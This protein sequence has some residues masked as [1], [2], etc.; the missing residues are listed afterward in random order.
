MN[1][2]NG[3]TWT[4]LPVDIYHPTLKHLDIE[5]AWLGGE[6]SDALRNCKGIRK[7]NFR[8][9]Y[10]DYMPTLD[11][12][13]SDALYN[14]EGT[15]WWYSTRL[16][17]AIIE[18]TIDYFYT[19][20]P[21]PKEFG[22]E[23]RDLFDVGDEQEIVASLGSSVAL[24]CTSAGEQEEFITYQ[25]YK[26]GLSMFGKTGRTLTISSLKA[27]D[28]ADY[29]VKITND[30]VKEYDQNSNYGEVFTK[31]FHIVAEPVAP[32]V[33]WAKTTY[34]GKEIVLRFTKPMNPGA[35]G[36]QGFVIRTG[37]RTLS[38]T[39]ARTGG[40]LDKDFILTLN[41]PLFMNEV[42]FIDYIGTDLKDK[43]NGILESFSDSS[44]VNLVRQEPSLLSAVTTRDGSG[45]MVYFDKYIDP[46]SIN[47]ADF[48]ITRDGNNEIASATL[49][50]GEIDPHISKGVLLTLTDP[51]SDSI[52][53]LGVQYI[54][55]ELSGYLS[56]VVGTSEEIDVTNQV[57]VDL[58]EVL[59]TFE[60][61]S[62]S[63]GN[64]LID[65]SWRLDP[66][67]MYDD[68]SHGDTVAN[69]H[70]WA[71]V[72]SLV[73]D[74]YTWDVLSRIHT[75]SYDTVSSE[76]PET[77]IITLIITPNEI[78]N[79][80]V[81]SENVV[82]EFEVSDKQ[83]TGTTGFGIMNIPVTFI[84]TLDH[85]SDQVFLM[86]IAEDWG[87]GIPMS[88]LDGSFRY[89]A[90]IP[91]YTVGDLISY[92]YRDGSIWENQTVEPR[93]YIV[94]SG[95]NLI[96]NTFG[97]F[98]TSAIDLNPQ[99]IGLYPNPVSHILNLTG[100]QH[101]QFIEIYNSSGVLIAHSP[102]YSA[103]SLQTD[104]S[105]FNAGIYLVKLQSD[106]GTI[107]FIKFIKY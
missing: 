56:G 67:Q 79:D 104:V 41:E 29:T 97:Q 107:L 101:F 106:N 35:A 19:I 30:Y 80:S 6:I 73:D 17:Y 93:S 10:I 71:T 22:I 91:G 72:L 53:M 47:P 42:V 75:I 64:V 66:L 39:A 96:N 74:S 63:I 36:Y 16:S 2:N 94:K 78:N 58:T 25:W 68:G 27:S 95:E 76:D 40:R 31:P 54:Q 90:T 13:D 4:E 87:V 100:L 15:Q 103:D 12:L 7:M 60:D 82:L 5:S 26:N 46:V 20:S 59:L 70:N 98:P 37:S 105:D 43:N 69:D 1:G 49:L 99:H 81:L 86:G 89:A 34:N 11:F 77:G 9:N 102:T 8:Y 28:Y 65:A 48:L 33:E 23:A 85:A 88:F 38:A 3:F 18:K 50:P 55:G 62:N 92:N 61:G 14:L 83:V 21:N 52:E 84:V 24:E 45:I 51:V 32:R 44:V 57:S